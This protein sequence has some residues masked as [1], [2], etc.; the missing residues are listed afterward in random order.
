MDHGRYDVWDIER[1]HSYAAG[2][3]TALSHSLVCPGC[4]VLWAKHLIEGD[5][6]IWPRAQFCEECEII[7]DAWHPVPG[8]LLVNEGFDTIDESLLDALPLDLLKREYQLTEKALTNGYIDSH[9]DWPRRA[10]AIARG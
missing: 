2:L 9:A 5:H 8:S 3:R 10:L 1:E 6:W 7:P 4:N